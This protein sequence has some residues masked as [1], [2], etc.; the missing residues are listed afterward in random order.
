MGP[1][2][3]AAGTVTAVE[4]CRLGVDPAPWTWAQS[5]AGAI[6]AHWQRRRA[7][8]PAFFNGV[9]YLC[10]SLAIAGGELSARFARTDFASYLYWRETGFRDTTMADM[11]GS[12]AVRSAEGQL[13]LGIQRPG[14]VNSGMALLPG[15]FIDER[16]V[17]VDGAIDIEASIARELG[18]E[19]GLAA[20]ELVR[21]PG[22]LVIGAR[23]QISIAATYRSHLP[24]AA[25]VENVSRSLA[26]DGDGELARVIAVNRAYGLGTGATAEYVAVL[27]RYL[28]GGGIAP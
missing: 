4:R 27:T 9:I 12:A 26:R 15:G 16:D 2:P 3:A 19:T 7:E 25:L 6:A 1:A 24:A 28:Y 17:T 11:F 21:E 5:E 10:S 8:N 23:P 22:F 14:N 13:L 20:G 18:E